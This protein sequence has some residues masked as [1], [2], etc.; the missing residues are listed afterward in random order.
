MDEIPIL[1]QLFDQSLNG[2]Q[3]FLFENHRTL[4]VFDRFLLRLNYLLQLCVSSLELL[5]FR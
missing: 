4:N 3:F 2:Y 5:N 1:F